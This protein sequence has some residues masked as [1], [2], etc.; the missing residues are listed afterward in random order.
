MGGNKR[1]WDFFKQYNGLEQ[2]MIDAKYASSAANYYRRKIAHEATYLPFTDKEPP[3]NADEFIDRGVGQ[4][5][6]VAFAAGKEI[7]TLGGKIGEKFQELGI[8][9][10]FK[11]MFG[12]KDKEENA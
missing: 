4:A 9:D 6:K 2:K 10:K 5:K 8:K 11:G 7:T 1:L 12:K 3:K